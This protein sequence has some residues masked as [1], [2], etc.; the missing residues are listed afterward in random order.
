MINFISVWF[1]LFAII[2]L[3]LYF[4]C[5]IRQRWLVLLAASIFFYASTGLEALTFILLSANVS[6]MAARTIEDIY[7]GSNP[8]KKKAKAC[9]CIGIAITLLLLFYSKTSDSIADALAAIF[10]SQSIDLKEIMPLGISYYTFSII[11]YMTDVYWKKQKAEHN[12]LK[13]FLYMAYFPQ[14]LQGPI[15]RYRTLAP[16]LFEGHAFN[17][18]N[19]CFGL[20]RMIWG[21]FKKM[22]I[23]DRFSLLTSEVFGNYNSYEGLI[24]V[25]AAIFSAIELYCDFSG[26]MDIALGF[27]EI[28]SIRLDENFRRPFYSKSASEFWHRWHITL[29]TWFRDYIYMPLVINPSF[30]KLCQK[31]KRA[32]GHRFAKSLMS[33]VPL[34]VVWLLTG[35]WHGTGSDYILW[36][37]Y[38]GLIIIFS[39]LLSAKYKKLAEKMHINRSSAFY[40]RFQI[41]R[42]CL[43]YVISRL[44][45]M[46]EDLKATGEIIRSIF[47]KFNIWVLFDESLYGIGLDRKDFWVGIIAVLILWK[48]SSLQEK[49][50]KVRD[51]IASY[52]LII[53]WGIYYI[54]ILSI[55]IFGIYGSKQPGS[56]FI[57]MSY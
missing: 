12:F 19:M 21:Y 34:A 35:L 17:Y 39:T 51:K 49:G 36:G 9:L 44:L 13:F 31:S 53:R 57:Y 24:F 16:Q 33:V 54:G 45:I 46:P 40:K 2:T 56:G 27:S 14:I 4:L 41:I 1:I 42:T 15:P 18:K 32:F 22:V 30:V 43:I 6:Y 10:S 29:G 55:L 7:N 38:W 25:I 8:S 26:C 28:I 48:V 52:P 23:A 11:G 50:I 37:C 20:Q 47:Q 5:P 3:I